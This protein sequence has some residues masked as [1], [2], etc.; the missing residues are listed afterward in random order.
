MQGW[1]VTGDLNV[2]RSGHTA[3]LLPNDQVLVVGGYDGSG[4]QGTSL[5]SAELYHPGSEPG[6]GT[7]TLTGSTFYDRLGHT[8]TL[9]HSGNVLVVGGTQD[10]NTE[11]YN[12]ATGEW[13]ATGRLNEARPSGHTAT[14][15][16]DGR[17]MVVGGFGQGLLSSAEIY[18]PNTQIWT[19]TGS[20]NNARYGQ[21]CCRM[22]RFWL[23]EESP[24]TFIRV[25]FLN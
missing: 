24:T 5:P 14:L 16:C 15:L 9:L 7:W 2:A 12:P 17:V 22:A 20:L 4:A 3:T 21:T 25:V 11:L 23:L 8:A 18:D 13:Y 10:T 19:P 1:E 6:S